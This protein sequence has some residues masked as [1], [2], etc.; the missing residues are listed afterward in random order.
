MINAL[1]II[2]PQA[3]ADLRV[4]REQHRARKQAL[5]DTLAALGSSTRGVQKLLQGLARE[6]DA[7]LKAVWQT[8]GLPASLAL[9]GVGGYGRGELFPHSDVDVVVLLPDSGRVDCI[10]V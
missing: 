1:A 4:L 7:T 3:P 6:A 8:A 9:L 5:L 2:Q 10:A